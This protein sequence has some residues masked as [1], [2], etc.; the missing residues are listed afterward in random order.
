[1]YSV[2]FRVEPGNLRSVVG[3]TAEPVMKSSEIM[4]NDNRAK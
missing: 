4:I 2:M 3:A 1:M